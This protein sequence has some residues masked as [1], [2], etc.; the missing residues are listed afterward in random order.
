GSATSAGLWLPQG[1]AVDSIGNICIADTADA[2]VRKITATTGIIT[3]VAGSGNG[4][5]SGD[6]GPALNAGFQSVNGVA[7]DSQGNIYIADNLTVRKVTV[8]TGIISKIAGAG[9][10]YGGDGGPATDALTAGV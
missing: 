2:R 3:T 10:R 6:G 5:S 1:V 9:Y 8:S 4:P 7:V